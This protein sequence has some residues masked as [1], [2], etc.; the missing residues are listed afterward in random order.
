MSHLLFMLLQA[1]AVHAQAAPPAAPAAP[2]PPPA[3]EGELPPLLVQPEVIDFVQAPYPEA[4]KAE[5]L[6]GTVGLLIEIDALGAVSAVEVLRPAGHGF[7]EAAVEAAKR[8]R[9]RP[10]ADQTGPVPV[11]IEFDYGFVLDA[12]TVKSAVPEEPLPAAAPAPI[13][14]EGVLVEM[15]TRVPLAGVAVRAVGSDG[16]PCE[17]STDAQGKWACRG[18]AVGPAAITA[19]Q[20]GYARVSETVEVTAGEVAEVKLWIK[21]LS[22][23]DNEIVGVYERKREP[24]VTRRTI[25]VEEVRR[26]PGTFGDPVRVIQNLPGAARAPFGIGLLV[27]RGSN[28]EDSNVYIDGVEIPLIFHLGGY[29]SVVNA[30][31]I[32]SVDYLPGSYGVRYGESTGGV[33]DVQSMDEF[34]EQSKLTW[35]TDALDTGVFFKGKVG[36]EKD[37]GIAVG[38]RRSYIDALIPLFTDGTGFMVKPRWYDYQLKVAELKEG[39]SEM[40]AFV[41]GFQ[42]ILFFSTPD[43]F[44][45]GTDQDT[46]GDVSVKYQ[47]HRQIFRMKRRLTDELDLVLQPVVGWDTINFGFGQAFALDQL[48]CHIG[49]RAELPWQPS[50]KLR[51]S[52][53]L[54]SNLTYYDIKF[55]LPFTPDSFNSLDPIGEREAYVT[56]VTGML[57]QPDPFMD[58]QWRP[59]SDPEK[60]LINP[61][62]R[63]NVLG[64]PDVATVFAVDPRVS[65]RAGLAP[66]GSLKVGTGLH[67]QPPQG[68][69]FGTGENLTTGFERAWSSELGWEQKVGTALTFDVTGFYKKLDRLIIQ[70]PELQDIETD[71]LYV[72]EGVG[73]IYG[74]EV[75]ARHALVNKVFGWVSYTLSESRRNDT[76]EDEDA[77]YP[78]D[79]DQTH[80]LV[81]LGGYRLPRDFEVSGKLSYVTGNPTTPFAGGVY[82]LDQDS[83]SGYQTADY[84]SE[85]LPPYFSMDF[86]V[87]KLFTFKRW[88]LETFLDLLNAVHGENPEQVQY[89]YDYTESAFVSGLPF[90]PSPGFQAEFTF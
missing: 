73:E 15:G 44:A 26:I 33:I 11:A 89:N 77:W 1:P 7:D 75:L 4:A 68:Q 27:I 58:L 46:Q 29:R 12:T 38:G 74:L 9:F 16:V 81:A 22:Y 31:A 51:L 45:Q 47:T 8:F 36:K 28:P 14:L 79:F 72:N 6:Q 70:N 76:P 24:E 84:N 40:S 48:F 3:A 23:A 63:V 66:G 17:T 2:A 60:L 83:Y 57:I 32:R 90:I 21:N 55:E 30:E 39:P 69:E 78:F 86:R 61:G 20:P 49:L 88:Q 35:R 52:T 87:S 18:V 56:T 65:V 41:F 37:V 62:L 67:Q 34:P 50:E 42:D 19:A 43:D 80:I 85:R 53:G 82:D 59:L 25:S 54:D 64:I 71:P 13:N 5:G 10:A